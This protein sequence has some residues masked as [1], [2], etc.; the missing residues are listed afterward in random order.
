MV[1]MRRASTLTGLLIPVSAAR[2]EVR[3][4]S[5]LSLVGSL[6]TTSVSVENGSLAGGANLGGLTA[7][8]GISFRIR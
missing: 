4:V 2:G 6:G 3:L 5:R 7:S 1:F 8:L